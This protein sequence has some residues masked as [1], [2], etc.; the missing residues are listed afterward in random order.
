MEQL[1]ESCSADVEYHIKMPLSNQWPFER[2]NIRNLITERHIKA[3]GGDYIFYSI[4]FNSRF[5]DIC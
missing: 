2:P 5:A 1:S 3:E 4:S